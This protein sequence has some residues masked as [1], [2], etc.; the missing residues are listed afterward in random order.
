MVNLFAQKKKTLVPTAY[1]FVPYN[2]DQLYDILFSVHSTFNCLVSFLSKHKWLSV[3]SECS[4]VQ[5]KFPTRS[6]ENV[7]SVIRLVPVR[8]QRVRPGRLD[9]PLWLTFPSC[10][11]FVDGNGGSGRSGYVGNYIGSVAVLRACNYGVV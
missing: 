1:F 9:L 3:L 8:W 2:M 11:S 4:A 6:N 10:G 5:F 7:S